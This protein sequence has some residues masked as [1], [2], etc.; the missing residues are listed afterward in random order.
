MMKKRNWFSLL[1][2]G[3]LVIGIG[4][5]AYDAFAG[6][7]RW[8]NQGGPGYGP[9]ASGDA[10]QRYT[11]GYG[12][13]NLTEEQVKALDAENEAFFDATGD[14]RSKIYQ[15]RLE[16]RSEMAKDKVDV[17]KAKGLQKE[18]SALESQLDEK[19]IEHMVRVKEIAPEVAQ[20][21]YGR[22]G[23]GKRF[24]GRGQGGYGPGSCWN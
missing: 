16:L 22:Q 6:R 9:S 10:D 19:R 15:K 8:S 7:G 21:N 23:R 18:I 14:I 12:Y 13:S 1:L 5:S 2:I 24:M 17:D 11:R 4:F 3:A 20:G